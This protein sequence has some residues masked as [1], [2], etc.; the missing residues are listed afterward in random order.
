MEIALTDRAS[1]LKAHLLYG[2]FQYLMITRAVRL[3]NTGTASITVKKAMSVEMTMNTELDG[4]PSQ[5]QYGTSD[6]E[7]S[8]WLRQLVR[9]EYP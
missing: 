8:P 2:V 9:G 1:G 3:E 7:N 4:S 6:G 5:T